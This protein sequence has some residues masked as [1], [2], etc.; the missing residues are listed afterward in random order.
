MKIMYFDTFV[1]YTHLQKIY[2]VL[3]LKY[4]IKKY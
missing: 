1:Y 4:Y 3:Q 2:N